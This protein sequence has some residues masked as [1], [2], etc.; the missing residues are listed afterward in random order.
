MVRFIFA[1]SCV[2]N[3]TVITLGDVARIQTDCGDSTAGQLNRMTIGESAPAGFCRFVNSSDFV[4]FAMHARV[5]KLG[6]IVAPN[7]RILVKT[8]FQ[9]KTIGEFS[10]SIE[11]YVADKIGWP[12]AAYAVSIL[13]KNEVWKCLPQPI[14][15]AVEG[16]VLKFQKGNFNLKL[17][18]LQGTR[19]IVTNISCFIKI[20]LP[21]VV[22]KTDIPRGTILSSEN[23]S[24]ETRDITQ[25]NYMPIS[26]LKE[27]ENTRSSRAIAMGSILHETL[28]SKI[29]IIERDDQV[30]VTVTHGRVTI[31][32]SG[33]ARESGSIGDKI[34]V[35][36]EMTHKLLKT[37]VIDHGK[38]ILITAEGTI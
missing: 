37:K 28:L 38:V 3:D 16:Q 14:S 25:C 2:V 27:I 8:G 15:I 22:A 6:V 33:R 21:V 26:A 23:S 11:K 4:S 10:D 30:V 5:P 19:R 24:I 36:N 32:M 9:K 13:N 17:I 34:W 18:G 35:E 12:Q 20:A 1:D 29:P 7:K 31:C